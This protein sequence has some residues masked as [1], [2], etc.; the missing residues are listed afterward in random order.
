MKALLMSHSGLRYLV[1]LALVALLVACIVGITSRQPAGKAVRITG[2]AFVGL[3]DLQILLGL[4]VLATGVWY[5]ALIGH[6][7]MMVLAAGVA[8]VMLAKN[9]RLPVPGYKLPLIGAIAAVVLVVGGIFAIPTCNPVA[10]GCGMIV[11]GVMSG[12]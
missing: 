5:S 7:V 4:G 11:R 6:I 1:L 12:G 10:M 9:R 2:A 3:L 8:H